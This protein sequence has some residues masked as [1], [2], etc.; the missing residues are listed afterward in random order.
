MFSVLAGEYAEVVVDFGGRVE[1]L[2][3]KSRAR[4]R[5]RS[6]KTVWPVLLT[7]NGDAEA[8][9]ENVWSMGM[10]LLPYANR[11]AYVSQPMC[12]QSSVHCQVLPSCANMEQ[13]YMF[14]RIV[15]LLQNKSEVKISMEK[16]TAGY[17]GTRS[18]T[19]STFPISAHLIHT[20]AS[21]N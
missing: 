14:F 13:V 9:K 19:C 18:T 7:H 5:G 10:L 8:I 16:K 15:Y 1:D 11:I 21:H 20:Q 3:L 17:V 4:A 2:H 12:S 6:G